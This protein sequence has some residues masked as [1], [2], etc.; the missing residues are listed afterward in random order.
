MDDPRPVA[1]GTLGT[2]LDVDDIGSLLV[3]WDNGQSLHV[4]YGIDRVVKVEPDREG[5][6]KNLY[7]YLRE[8]YNSFVFDSGKEAHPLSHDEVIQLMTSPT[9][10]VDIDIFDDERNYHN[11]EPNIQLTVEEIERVVKN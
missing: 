7:T 11:L 4:L 6:I 8:G 2:V 10:K 9:A 5:F 3:S 1:V